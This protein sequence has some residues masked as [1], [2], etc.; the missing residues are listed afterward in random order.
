MNCDFLVSQRLLDKNS[1]RAAPPGTMISRPIASEKAQDRYRQALLGVMRQRQMFVEYLADCI[2]P[3][4]DMRWPDDQVVSFLERRR[5]L[6]VNIGGRGQDNFALLPLRRLQ[7]IP[8]ALIIDIECAK[9][10]AVA[11]DLPGGQMKD[12]RGPVD[13]RLQSRLVA[14]IIEIKF[15]TVISLVSVDEISGTVRKIVVTANR[16]IAGQQSLA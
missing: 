10:I 3:A 14:D 4:P 7:N 11:W 5:S 15:E 16:V 12:D 1:L 13:C 9:S 2:A 6:A 8:G